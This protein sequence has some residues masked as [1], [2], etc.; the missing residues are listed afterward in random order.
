MTDTLLYLKHLFITLLSIRTPTV[1]YDTPRTVFNISEWIRYSKTDLKHLETQPKHYPTISL[2]KER[3]LDS[4]GSSKQSG[5]ICPSEPQQDHQSNLWEVGW[6]CFL[7]SGAA[8]EKALPRIPTTTLDHR[9]TK[10][11]L[12]ISKF[13]EKHSLAIENV[14]NLE[15][16]G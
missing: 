9:T 11:P 8:T 16:E 15:K 1:I 4:W 5:L 7:Q 12:R 13:Y 6:W 10:S 2:K 3:I 14:N